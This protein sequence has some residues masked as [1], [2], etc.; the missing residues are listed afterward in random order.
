MPAGG[1]AWDQAAEMVE[2]DSITAA[3]TDN[4]QTIIDNDREQ[5]SNAVQIVGKA[6]TRLEAATNLREHFTTVLDDP[7][8]EGGESFE[9]L[10]VVELFTV[11]LGAVNWFVLT[12]HYMEKWNEGVR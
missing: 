4:L 5:L 12:D 3:A 6:T 7:R 11:M 2:A 9:R 1:N 10:A 8:P